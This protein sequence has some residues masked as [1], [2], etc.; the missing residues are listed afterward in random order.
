MVDA[1]AKNIL[2]YIKALIP[3]IL[4]SQHGVEVKAIR[5]QLEQMVK[6]PKNESSSMVLNDILRQFQS[7]IN[8]RI[9]LLSKY[10]NHI[11]QEISTRKQ[12]I[13]KIVASQDA[14]SITETKNIDMICQ[15]WHQRVENIQ[16]KHHENAHR[17]WMDIVHDFNL[18]NTI[19]FR[20]R[21]NN[22]LQTEIRRFL[23]TPHYEIQR[24]NDNEFKFKKSQKLVNI[25]RELETLISL[26][27]EKMV[28]GAKDATIYKKIQKLITE[29]EVEMEKHN[30]FSSEEIKL[31]SNRNLEYKKLAQSLLSKIPSDNHAGVLKWKISDVIDTE[32]S[33][34][35]ARLHGQNLDYLKD[36]QIDFVEQSNKIIDDN[37]HIYSQADQELIELAEFHSNMITDE[38]KPMLEHVTA[39]FHVNLS[40][41]TNSLIL[42]VLDKIA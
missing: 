10:L 26:Y 9:K 4:T 25:N 22:S 12:A 40:K 41:A 21:S 27:K 31:T 42:G 36:I 23:N 24:K 17:I 16:N 37:Y 33:K 39:K 6:A 15:Q 8:G 3:Y 29:R 35:K 7:A 28:L 2:K 32:C 5:S 18:H 1:Q 30:L 38:M 14:K 34:G 11:V 13:F 19:H 20:P